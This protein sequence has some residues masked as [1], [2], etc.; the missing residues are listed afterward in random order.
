MIDYLLQ[1]RCNGLG[2]QEYFQYV[3]RLVILGKQ[4]E[5]RIA[6]RKDVEKQGLQ[7]GLINF[8]NL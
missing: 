7:L 3:I 2:Q 8:C 5:A 1:I 6:F 4:M